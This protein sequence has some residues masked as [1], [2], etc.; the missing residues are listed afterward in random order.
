MNNTLPIDLAFENHIKGGR[1]LRHGRSIGDG[2]ARGLGIQYG[3]LRDQVRTH[4]LYLKALYA[5]AGRSIISEDNRINIFLLIRY[6]LPL[7]PKG[8]IVEFGSYRG[9]NA[10]FMAKLAAETLPGVRVFALDT[11]KGMPATD[12]AVDR[13][14]EG[15]FK[16]VDLAE[17]RKYSKSTGL[18][19]LEFV[20]GLF[21]DTAPNLLQQIDAISLSHID[22]DIA[23][24]CAFSF[25]VS[26]P[27]MVV[28]GYYVFDDA[29]YSSCLGATEV[30]EE[31]LIDRDKMR[32]EQ[33]FPHYVFRA[34][35]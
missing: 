11:F 18:N 23:S 25:D 24:A 13:H 5:D 15:D 12:A 27:K 29:L 22:C 19:N 28:G 33:I 9:G 16:D 32:S 3:K 1:P 31:I 34:G 14:V 30:V 4:P 26:K 20:E 21:E 35:L 10:L 6:F 7:L 8:D 17:L 2:Y